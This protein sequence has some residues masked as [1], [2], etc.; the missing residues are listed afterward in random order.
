MSSNGLQH[1]L[2]MLPVENV[3]RTSAE[4]RDQSVDEQPTPPNA[5]NNEGVQLSGNKHSGNRSVIGLHWLLLCLATFSAN[6]LQGLDT[7]VATDI[8]GAV[9]ATYN[10]TTELRWLGIGFELGLTVVILPIG[11]AYAIFETKWLFIWSIVNFAGGSALCGAVPS[12]AA[13]IVGRVWAGAGGAGM[14]LG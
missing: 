2:T 6:L 14:H 4:K 10:N 9:S 7:T 1:T 3:R 8:Q 12:M 5:S 11:E 13:P